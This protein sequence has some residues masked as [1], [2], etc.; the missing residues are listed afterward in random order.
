[1]LKQ[2]KRNKS[3]RHEEEEN[4]IKE[5]KWIFGE[6]SY[7]IFQKNALESN[8]VIVEAKSNCEYDGE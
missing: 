6:K 1:M 3:G 4:N 8:F 2:E 5:I 7:S